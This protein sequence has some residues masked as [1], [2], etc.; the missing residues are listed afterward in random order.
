MNK[1][2]QL[3]EDALQ[4][5]DRD[6][7]AQTAE[8]GYFAQ[9]FGL[10]RGKTAWVNWV[11]MLVQVVM[12]VASVWC[13]VQFF[14]AADVLLALKWGISTAV[15]AILATM[16]KLSLMP[17]MQADRVIRELKRIE[18]MLARRDQPGK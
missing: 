11:I 18:L 3:I 16:M 1:L 17:V 2:D 7:L 8:L 4:S 13:A 14:Q 9:A 6:I 10:F 12:F 15:L 5:E